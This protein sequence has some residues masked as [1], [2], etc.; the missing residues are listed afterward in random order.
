MET[1]EQCEIYSKL[2]KKVLNNVN[3]V[4]QSAVFI[5]NFEHISYLILLFP[6]LNLNK[7]ILAGSQS[8]TKS[9]G[10]QSHETV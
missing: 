9:P 8:A 4:G 6:L 2:T 3:D 7:E 1:P 5:L 10:Y